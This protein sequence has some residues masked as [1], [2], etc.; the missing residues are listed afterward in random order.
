MRVLHLLDS[1]VLEA[2][3]IAEIG[4]GVLSTPG[5]D[6]VVDTACATGN[7]VGKG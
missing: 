5:T 7:R 2:E 4:V 3:L 1:V 6:E